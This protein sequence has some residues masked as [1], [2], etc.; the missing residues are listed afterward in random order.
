[1]LSTFIGLPNW[2]WAAALFAVNMLLLGREHLDGTIASAMVVGAVNIALV[3]AL[4]AIALAHADGANFQEVRVPLLDGRP[5]DTS[6]LG[7]IFGVVMLAFFGH[8]SAANAAKVVL[9]RDPSGRA[10]LRGNV[11]ALTVATVLYALTALAF[12]GALEAESLSGAAGTALE[13]LADKGG[14]AVEVLGSLFAML[15]IGMGSVYCSL[16]LY[17]Q[18]LEWRPQRDRT[19]R[20][21][22]GAAV[23][24]FVFV[25]TLWL[26]ASNRESFTAPLGYVGALTV[27]LLGG[28]MPMVLVVASRRRGELV[29]PKATLIGNPVVA[30]LVSL[31]F[32]AGVLVQALWIWDAVL[33]QV[34]GVAVAVVMAG[35][36]AGAWRLGAFRPRTVIE[37]RREPERDIGVLA[38][39]MNGHSVAPPVSVDGHSATS[40][41][42]ERFSQLREVVVDLPPDA[43]GEV[44]VW[45]HRLSPDGDSEDI[46]MRVEREGSK[47][48]IRP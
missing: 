9:E 34:A 30:A 16:G 33:A 29:P 32:L 31:L 46:P 10:L 27:P 44:R 22:V 35:A 14:V 41:N 45:A 18:V 42:F 20:L 4:C 25:F 38:V 3:L 26:V 19:R 17:N 2:V 5:V 24:T 43:P 23:P 48:V 12:G 1:V 36:I 15:A 13:P 28:V 11:A 8:T 21:V 7:L 37:L 39:T 40:G 6:I 47:V